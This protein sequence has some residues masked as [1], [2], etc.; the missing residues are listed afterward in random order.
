MT[1]LSVAAGTFALV[2]S[3]RRWACSTDGK[4]SLYLSKFYA[5]YIFFKIIKDEYTWGELVA[6]CCCW[7]RQQQLVAIEFLQEPDDCLCPYLS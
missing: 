1:S 3:P 7:R 6:G 2:V 5:I 4:S